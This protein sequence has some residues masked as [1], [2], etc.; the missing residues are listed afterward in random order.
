[1][2]ELRVDRGLSLVEALRR[3]PRMGLLGISVAAAV[4]LTEFM[5]G[6]FSLAFY[7]EVVVSYLWMGLCI[8]SVVSVLLGLAFVWL[9]S[10]LDRVA[11]EFEHLAHR[12]SLTGVLNRRMYERVIRKE[13][14][15]ARRRSSDLALLALDVDHF[16]RVND[17]RGHAIG[18]SLLRDLV[19]VI[20]QLLRHSDYLFRIG[21]DELLILAPDTNLSRAE[22]LG[23]RLRQTVSELTHG[24]VGDA[25]VSIGVAALES[26]MDHEQLLAAADRALY[27]AKRAGR[28]AVRVAGG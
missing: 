12:D 10:H 13:I 8:S 4:I 26:D 23:V 2:P 7:G 16:K 6:V 15:Y 24:P 21:G 27:V 3:M 18:D 9:I 1:M 22:R 5:A 20:A 25:T 19:R 17:A 14:A 11:G 28:N